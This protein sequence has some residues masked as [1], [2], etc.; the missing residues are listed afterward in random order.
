[1]FCR[2]AMVLRQIMSEKLIEE[3]DCL[4]KGAPMIL[5]L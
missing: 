3:L 2:C 1:M 5:R 4:A